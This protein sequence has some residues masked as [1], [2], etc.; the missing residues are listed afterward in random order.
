MSTSYVIE[1]IDSKTIDQAYPLVRATGPAP[2]LD[3][4]RQLCRS[5]D[6]PSIDHD[7]KGDREEII[8]ARNAQGYVKGLCVYSVRAHST[9]GRVVDV[10]FFVVASA[11]DGEGVAAELLNFLRSKCD[12]SVCSGIRFW[13]AS[14]DAWGK[15]LNPEQIRK[16][17]H[18]LFMPALASANEMERALCARGIGNFEVIGRLSR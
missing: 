11:A 3:E 2:L 5:F 18:G 13:D 1:P 8:V 4:W 16:T 10:P 15:R 12:E 17:D 6:W 14:P 7:V 9:Y